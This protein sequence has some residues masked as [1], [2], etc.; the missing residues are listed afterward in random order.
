MPVLMVE[1]AA[2]MSGIGLKSLKPVISL[3]TMLQLA[4]MSSG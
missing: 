3:L 4:M 2:I 1:L